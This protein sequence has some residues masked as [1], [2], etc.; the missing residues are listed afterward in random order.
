ME[1]SSHPASKLRILIVD[2]NEDTATSLGLLLK[3]EGHD[4]AKAFDGLAAI[5]TAAAYDPQVIL[6]D[7]GLPKLDG[8]E[9]CARLRKD[10]NPALRLMVALT[11]WGEDE[12]RQRATAAGF[13]HHMVKPIDPVELRKIL[14]SLNGKQED[15]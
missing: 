6:M 3:L 1:S 10:P 14:T 9:A 7:I 8:Y 4:T 15:Q 13:D 5:E 2:D 11:G 12:D